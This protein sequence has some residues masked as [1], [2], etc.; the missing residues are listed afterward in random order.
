MRVKIRLILKDREMV[1][2]GLK[3]KKFHQLE[4]VMNY[5]NII[6]NIL[7]ALAIDFSYPEDLFPKE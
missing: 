6:L 5:Y 1:S 2:I 3:F 7:A 4:L